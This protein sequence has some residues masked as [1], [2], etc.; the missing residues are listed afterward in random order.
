MNA[1]I[2]LIQQRS[3]F[4][5]LEEPAPN[6]ETLQ[7]LFESALNVPDHLHLRPWRFLSIRDNDRYA[8]GEVFA[9]AV[10]VNNP[11]ASKEQLDKKASKT[12]RAPLIIVGICSYIEHEKVPEIEQQLSTGCVL[13]NLGLALY[14]LNFASIWRTGSFAFDKTVHQELGLQAHESIAGFLYVGT[15]AREAKTRQPFKVSDYLENWPN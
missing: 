8:L 11:N 5:K 1:I 13:H 7:Q 14:S 4:S 10:K 6:E 9:N 3:S 15:A 12:L 2:D